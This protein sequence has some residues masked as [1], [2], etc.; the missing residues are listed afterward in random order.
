MVHRV[1]GPTQSAFIKRRFTLDGILSLHKIVH[2]IKIRGSKAIIL[3]LDF[4]KAYYCVRWSFLRDVLLA[5]GFDRAYVHRIMQFVC[6]GHTVVS[7]NGVV[8]LFFAN[9]RGIK[10]GDPISPFIFNFI[11]DALSC[12]LNRAASTGHIKPVMSPLT[13]AGVSHL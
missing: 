7:D 5:K 13:S 12:I 4:E 8:S 11:A 6:G 3:K 10:Q 2:D 9:S 1:I